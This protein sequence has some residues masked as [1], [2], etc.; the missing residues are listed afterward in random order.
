MVHAALHT[1]VTVYIYMYGLRA[2]ILF[3]NKK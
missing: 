1:Y 3:A 2:V